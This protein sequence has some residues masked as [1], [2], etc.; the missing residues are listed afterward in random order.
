MATELLLG[1][2]A[3][4]IGMTIVLIGI[5]MMGKA[6]A[7]D[8]SYFILLTGI[9][10]AAVAIYNWLDV[11]LPLLTAQTLL[12]AFTYLWTFGNWF[13]GATDTRAEGWYCLLVVFAGIPFTIWTFQS[14][15]NILGVN[16]ITW[17]VAWFAFWV[18]MGLQKPQAI[19]PTIAIC[20]VVGSFLFIN[21]LAWLLGWWGF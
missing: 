11:G 10:S 15:Y 16:W 7:K 18:V 12:F 13:T 17:L 4:Y 9:I 8:L 6:A 1:L 5:V 21:A 19:K 20:F 3:L 14:G 2:P